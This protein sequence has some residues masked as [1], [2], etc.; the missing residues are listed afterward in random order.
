MQSA[1]A[2]LERDA[3]VLRAA[4]WLP[5]VLQ[6][7]QHGE[8]WDDAVARVAILLAGCH[9][10]DLAR[11]WSD[12][13]DDDRLGPREESILRPLGF[14][15]WLAG[16]RERAR[17]RAAREATWGLGWATAGDQA[18]G[19]WVLTTFETD[20]VARAEALEGIRPRHTWLGLIRAQICLDLAVLTGDVG[21]ACD[22]WLVP[23]G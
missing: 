1:I 13:V 21:K 20:P 22:G 3:A 4:E 8:G 11:Q 23:A 19:Q 17:R 2:S 9:A 7:E 15:D 14:V 6:Q 16:E 10:D 18:L 12:A 5:A